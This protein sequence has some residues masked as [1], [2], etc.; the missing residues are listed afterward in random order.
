MSDA[1]I[2]QILRNEK[3]FQSNYTKPNMTCVAVDL[4]SIDNVGFYLED[5]NK[6]LQILCQTF[7]CKD[8]QCNFVVIENFL[9]SS[10]QKGR[11]IE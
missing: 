3:I 4:T 1:K 7:A 2:L 10:E 8:G 9:L 6:L 11:S 5:C